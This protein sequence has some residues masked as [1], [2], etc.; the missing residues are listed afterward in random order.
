MPVASSPN[1]SAPQG[2]HLASGSIS[3]YDADR[4][5]GTLIDEAGQEWPFH[6]TA[7][8]GGSRTI[9]AG[10]AVVFELAAGHL[11]LLE[12]RFVAPGHAG[13]RPRE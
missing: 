8:A 7:I 12:A 4:G 2:R 5:L 10:T 1:A 3:A 9:D 13:L 11:G 6:C